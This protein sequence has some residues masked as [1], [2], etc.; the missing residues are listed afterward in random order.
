VIEHTL[1]ERKTIHRSTVGRMS[2]MH[3]HLEAMQQLATHLWSPTAWWHP[4]G[5]AWHMSSVPD[6]SA[7]TT[8]VWREGPRVVAW[9]RV[10]RGGLLTALI[11]PEHPARADEIVTS[12]GGNAVLT[13]DAD[14]SLIGALTL[15][16]F[17]PAGDSTPF[18]LDMR[19][20]ASADHT[21]PVPAGYRVRGADPDE[22]AALVALHRASWNP[23]ELPWTDGARPVPDPSRESTFTI[24]AMR[25]VENAPLYRRDLH[26]VAE[27]GDG[28]LA[29]SCIAWLDPV[30]GAAEIEPVGTH[31]AHR[32][33]GLAA[34]VCLEAV[35]RVGPLGGN[36]VV[37]HPRGDDA[38]LVPRAVYARCGF[39]AVGRTR[40]YTR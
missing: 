36:E 3:D 14:T 7:F 27:S 38:Y 13:A 12:F 6:P 40:L 19:R 4:G 5:L 10:E 1:E 34:S 35:R 17:T 18:D 30:T 31:P 2:S 32:G 24:E 33:R 20:P 39:E 16:G 9:A 37:I 22:S 25:R 28:E 21:V 11:D 23:S 26:V 29:S 8:A 15:A